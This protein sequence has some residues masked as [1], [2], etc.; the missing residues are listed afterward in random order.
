MFAFEFLCPD[1]SE[2][3]LSAGT[4]FFDSQ[5]PQTLANMLLIIFVSRW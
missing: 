2:S 4:D 3:L 5:L 1:P